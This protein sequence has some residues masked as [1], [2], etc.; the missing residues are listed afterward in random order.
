MLGRCLRSPRLLTMVQDQGI[1]EVP[2]NPTTRT[3]TSKS[4][5]QPSSTY[6]SVEIQSHAGP[7]REYTEAYGTAAP[8]P[9]VTSAYPS[10]STEP[11]AKASEWANVHVD[12]LPSIGHGSQALSQSSNEPRRVTWRPSLF[13]V[14][15]LVGLVALLLACLQILASGA[16]LAGS[17]GDA[18]ANWKLQPAV[19]LAVLTAISNEAV[20]FAAIQG[21]VVTFWLRALEGTTLGQLRRDWVST[22]RTGFTYHLY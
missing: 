9:P 5:V 1:A 14:G 15:P 16:V 21:T 8:T 6:Q 18:V 10:L 3:L 12:T 20:A 13:Q 17:D 4:Q 2:G 22:N 19:Y 7:R 11:P